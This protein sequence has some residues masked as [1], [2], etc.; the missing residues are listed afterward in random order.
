[1]ESLGLSIRGDLGLRARSELLEARGLF[2]R[3]IILAV[4]I[5][6]DAYSSQTS[7]KLFCAEMYVSMSTVGCRG[8]ANR[9]TN[10][11]LSEIE[12]LLR[13]GHV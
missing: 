3:F 6:W 10:I 9:A 4:R 1:M 8:C 13:N 7:A 12:S 2:L 11:S 5:A